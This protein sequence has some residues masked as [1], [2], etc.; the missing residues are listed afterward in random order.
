[1]VA[2]ERDTAAVVVDIQ[3]VVV[4]SQ[5]VV[6]GSQAAV[7]RSRA[8]VEGSLAVEVGSR[9][10]V[11]LRYTVEVDPPCCLIVSRCRLSIHRTKVKISLAALFKHVSFP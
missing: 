1:V 7:V 2:E 6:V 8:A 5:V 4:G 3:V 11:F 10:E 9:L